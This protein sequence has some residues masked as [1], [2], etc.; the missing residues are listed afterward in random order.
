[1]S[2]INIRKTWL[3]NV[4]DVCFVTL[5]KLGFTIEILWSISGRLIADPYLDKNKIDLLDF[6]PYLEKYKTIALL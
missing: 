3:S 6:V 5:L 1:M 4:A 2:L